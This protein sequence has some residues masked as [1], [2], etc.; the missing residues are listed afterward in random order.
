MHGDEVTIDDID[1][2]RP[3]GL[4][5]LENAGSNCQVLFLLEIAECGVPAVDSIENRVECHVAHVALHQIQL[6]APILRD[7]CGQRQLMQRQIVPNHR[8]AALRELDGVIASTAT[9]VEHDSTRRN[10]E[11]FLDERCLAFDL[12]VTEPAQGTGEVLVE[13]LFPPRAPRLRRGFVVGFRFFFGGFTGCGRV[14]LSTRST[15]R[16]A[17]RRFSASLTK[18]WVTATGWRPRGIAFGNLRGSLCIELGCRC[19][20]DCGYWTRRR[21]RRLSPDGFGRWLGNHCASA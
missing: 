1:Q 15:G 7:F 5:R 9:Q 18:R 20:R 16:I 2:E 3:T 6:L 13:Q 14:L 11:R 12:L 17:R 8:I 19:V 10:A 21:G 4:E